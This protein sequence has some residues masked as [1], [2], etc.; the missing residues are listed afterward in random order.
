LTNWQVQLDFPAKTTYDG[1]MF[2]DQ[3]RLNWLQKAPNPN[4][5]RLREEWT[6]ASA[7]VKS[8]HADF[9]SAMDVLIWLELHG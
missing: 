9:R 2:T 6:N 8:F 3:E 4:L 7:G 1:G 5:A